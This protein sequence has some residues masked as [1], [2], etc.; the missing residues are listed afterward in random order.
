MSRV[1]EVVSEIMVTGRAL[2]Q[3][4]R[5]K[6]VPYA[7]KLLA[8][9]NDSLEKTL[10]V[11]LALCVVCAILVSGSAVALKS[12]QQDNKERDIKKNILSVVGLMQEGVDIDQAFSRIEQK[13]VN[14]ESGEY[15]ETIDPTTYNQRKAARV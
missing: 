5:N 8:L 6:C 7:E 2:Y 9:P 11:A 10:S 4:F 12:I 15:D 1:N 13:I 3:S 14:L